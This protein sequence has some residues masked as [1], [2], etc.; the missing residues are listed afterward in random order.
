M[1]KPT[2][3]ANVNADHQ[4]GYLFA[5]GQNYAQALSDFAQLTG[6]PVMLPKYAF[7]VIFSRYYPYHDT[8]WENTVVPA[9]RTNQVPLDMMGVDTD[10]KAP[11]QWNGWS[12]NSKY[13]PDPNGFGAWASGQNLHI[14][15]NIHPTIESTD[16]VY[17]SV[18]TPITGP[19]AV[20]QAES[21][22][23]NRMMFDFGQS[24]DVAAWTALNKPFIDLGVVPWLDWGPNDAVLASTSGLVT[25][26]WMNQL[27]YESTTNAGR[28][29]FS[30][31]R[32]GSK[33]NDPLLRVGPWADHRSTVHFTGDTF[34]TWAMLQYE[35]AFT[36][37]EAAIDEAYVSHDI[38]SFHADHLADDMYARWV[39]FGAFQ[40]AL[41]LH[42][43]HGDRL[44][45][46]YGATL[47]RLRRRRSSGCAK[48][49]C[50]TTIRSAGRPTRRG[51]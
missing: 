47:P 29:G 44:P 30:W 14:L 45:W 19:L 28:R 22:Q 26:S 39:Q 9:F 17:P 42:S 20:Q 7:G 37:A 3:R 8:D 18:V 23:G 50:L 10:W 12:W 27:Y 43:D 35:V 49:C 46:E 21:G 31:G 24:K 33:V 6:G 2:A 36:T 48:R 16:P 40:P 4:D 13:F 38:G 34:P 15:L 25:D 11:F 5:Y 1:G 51:W 32:I 41:R